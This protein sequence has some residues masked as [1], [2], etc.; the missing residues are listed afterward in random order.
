LPAAVNG[1]TAAGNRGTRCRPGFGH[2]AE[3]RLWR[4]GGMLLE[5]LQQ[6]FIFGLVNLFVF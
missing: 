5:Q 2:A 4:S 3:V 6:F 1:L